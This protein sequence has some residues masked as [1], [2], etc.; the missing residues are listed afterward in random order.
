MKK[1]FSLFSDMLGI[2]EKEYSKRWMSRFTSAIL[3]AILFTILLFFTLLFSHLHFRL[4]YRMCKMFWDNYITFSGTCISAYAVAWVG[5]MGKAF[6]AKREE[7]KMKL[8][9]KLTKS[10]KGDK[11]DETRNK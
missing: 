4:S 11:E 9:Y 6:L 2:H 8:Q 1:L 10:S 5:H 7:E 3:C